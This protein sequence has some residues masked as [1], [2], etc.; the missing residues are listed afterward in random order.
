[1]TVSIIVPYK[2]DRGFL[3][4]CIESIKAQTYPCELILSQSDN[5]V[6]YNFNRGLE[7]ATGEF[8]K[9]VCDDD[10][11]PPDSVSNLVNG[12]GDAPWVAANAIQVQGDYEWIYKPE[13][14]DFAANVELNR[15][16]GG[17]TL[18]RTDILREIGGLDETLWTGE[19]YDMNLKLMSLGYLPA[20]LDEEVYY[21]RLWSGGKSKRLR[22]TTEDKIKRENE[23]KRIQALYSDKV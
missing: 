6:S 23:I 20:Y 21:Y 7:K 1:M 11:L 22:R 9:Y 15:I 19:E 17:T 18:Y 16:H 13:T 10:W 5:S 3:A 8:V 4:Q 2:E 14:L 12:I